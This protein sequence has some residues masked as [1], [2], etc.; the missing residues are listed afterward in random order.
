MDQS[1]RSPPPTEGHVSRSFSRKS[2]NHSSTPPSSFFS[3]SDKR[4][5]MPP[6]SES[7]SLGVSEPFPT[8]ETTSPPAPLLHAESEPP[9]DRKASH[10]RT[11]SIFK[12]KSPSQ[13]SSPLLAI[14]K[15][16]KPWRRFRASSKGWVQAPIYSNEV[17]EPPRQVNQ[18]PR[19][20]TRPIPPTPQESPPTSVSGELG[21]ATNTPRRHNRSASL[22]EAHI[23]SGEPPS[24]VAWN[25]PNPIQRG[26]MSLDMNHAIGSVENS[27]HSSYNL[28]GAGERWERRERIPTVRDLAILPTQRVMRYVLL[29]K[30]P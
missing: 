18:A 15:S 11:F 23:S 20:P 30:G 26:G 3:F 19:R 12:R 17:V 24:S 5:T 6:M 14:P 13:T 16:E 25:A 4:K 7:L 9:P 2:F 21:E 1:K 29:F 22:Q 28:L 10:R 27:T 8:E